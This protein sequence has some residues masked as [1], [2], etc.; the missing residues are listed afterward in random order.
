MSRL[1]TNP[2]NDLLKTFELIDPNGDNNRYNPKNATAPINELL[3]KIF[4]QATGT[5]LLPVDGTL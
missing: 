5:R 2:T 1:L 4:K 3:K